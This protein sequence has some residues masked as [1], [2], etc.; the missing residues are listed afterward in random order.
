MM[1]VGTGLLV[2]G[3]AAVGGGLLLESVQPKRSKLA[4]SVAAVGI[5]ALVAGAAAAAHGRFAQPTKYDLAMPLQALGA[6]GIGESQLDAFNATTQLPG[7]WYL[8]SSEE[9]YQRIIREGFEM[10]P[11]GAYTSAPYF[12]SRPDLNYGPRVIAAAIPSDRPY[13]FAEPDVL[14]Y[15]QFHA[16]VR[17][18]VERWLADVPEGATLERD[19]QAERALMHAGY[20]ALKID[21]PGLTD[22]W[23]TPFHSDRL[24]IVVD[25]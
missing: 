16:E 22:T 1:H 18:L 21:R 2:G 11:Q 25:D 15:E 6:R 3:G 20:D 23:V 17:P 5:G 13:V 12:S 14:Q 19:V 7:R 8:A 4:R 24:R 9:R 10:D